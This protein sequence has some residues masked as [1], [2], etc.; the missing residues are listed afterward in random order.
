MVDE[1]DGYESFFAANYVPLV[2]TLWSYCG[3]REVAEEAAQEAF[4]RASRDWRQ[5]SRMSSPRG[6]L[7][8]VAINEANRLYRRRAAFW[9]AV[10]RHGIDDA[11]DPVDDVAGHVSLHQAMQRLPS[12][13]RAV[14]GLHYFAGLSVAEIAESIDAREGTVKSLL[15]RGR[16]VLG[17]ELDA[18]KEAD[19]VRRRA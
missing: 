10:T 19:D 14:L 9:R 1:F 15:S 8:R 2:R 18:S 13:Q 3:E 16:T 4:V 5:V 11:E 17:E 6:W 7:H 12:R